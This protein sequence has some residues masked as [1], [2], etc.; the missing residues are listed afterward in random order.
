V[1]Y[2]LFS[3]ELLSAPEYDAGLKSYIN[4]FLPGIS[5][6]I[7][8]KE[9]GTIPMTNQAFPRNNGKIIQL[10]TA[11]GQTK[12]SSGYTFRFIQKHSEAI[13]KELASGKPNLRLPRLSA[14]Y[15]FYDSVL[16]NVLATGKLP[17][18]QVFTR[19]FSKSKPQDI[20]Q[21]L[22]NESSLLQE[23]KLISSLPTL[24]F[25]KAGMEQL[26]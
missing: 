11:G 23:L 10:G 6:K 22:D 17:G 19:L 14:K 24:P 3:K 2:T 9:F 15:H 5:Y 12:A 26:L 1:E 18:H 20:F 4:T 7:T 8:E 16:L 13:V 25:L 21:F